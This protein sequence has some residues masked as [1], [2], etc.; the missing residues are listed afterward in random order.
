[1][2]DSLLNM[3]ILA[4]GADHLPQLLTGPAGWNAFWHGNIFHPD[5]Y[6]IALSEH[7]F[8]QVLQIAP[9]Y[10]L[11]GNA[12]LAYNLI[13]L[14]TFVLSAF[15]AFLLVRDLT[16]DWRAAFVAGLVYGFLPYR[17]AQITH[18]QV[19]SSQWMPFVLL[20]LH[21]YIAHRS[22]RALV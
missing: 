16:G 6:S 8:G 7:L 2:G 4:W 22:T 1:L 20:G 13:F 12:I 5:P 9:I 21:R 19:L 14:S 3:W 18:V 11:T 10:A 17:I 15:G